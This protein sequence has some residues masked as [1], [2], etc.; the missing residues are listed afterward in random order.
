MASDLQV[1]YLQHSGFAVRTHDTLL[2]FDDAQGSPED[3][4]SLA[5][6]RITRQLI[7]AY[8]QTV[9]F[10]SHAHAD[11][12]NP[13]IYTIPGEDSHVHY[14][15]GYDLPKKHRGNRLKPGDTRKV[16]GLAI[17]AHGS[18]DEGVSFLVQ[19]DGWSLFHAGDLNLWHWR[20]E[21]TPKEIEKAENDF[22]AAVQPLIGES[23]DF[24][25]FPVDPRMGE[26]SDAG[27]LYF[28]MHV[29]PRVMIPMHWWGRDAVSREFSRRNRSRHV[30]IVALTVP[31][32]TLRAEKDADGHIVI[33]L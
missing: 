10:V 11:H 15:L 17:T 14:V 19:A 1:T 21:S 32:E 31:G 28:L 22:Y 6:G 8:P 13:D 33:D 23:I 25:F 5:N 29:K 30:E 2:I 20:E 16:A 18:T 24:A 12:F 7:D 4:D 26:M 3:G 9:F 27:A